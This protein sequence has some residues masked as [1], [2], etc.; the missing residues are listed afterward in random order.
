M[1]RSKFRMAN[2]AIDALLVTF[3]P[4]QARDHRLDMYGPIDFE[5]ELWML[6]LAATIALRMAALPKGNGSGS[7][8]TG[9]MAV[10]AANASGE[11][12]KYQW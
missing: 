7:D 3:N 5:L 10:I 12:A 8:C 11:D 9:A 2:D 1:F 4:G 6:L